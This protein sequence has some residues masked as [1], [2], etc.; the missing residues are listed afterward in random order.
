MTDESVQISRLIPAPRPRVWAA[1][2]E[3]S[4]L[5]RWWW[6]ER[7][8]TTYAI[9]LREGGTFRFQSADL[10][11]IGVL[12]ITGRFLV[13][14]PPEEL[15][16]TWRWL[17]EEGESEVSVVFTARGETTEVRIMHDGLG[18][19]E[20]RHNHATGWND[21]LNRLVAVAGESLPA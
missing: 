20:D 4:E 10:P 13:V 7:F 2:T 18:S 8:H 11:D 1:W 19:L 15:R 12:G 6:P 17:H 16:Y 5:A 3:P 14:R 9:D 21:C